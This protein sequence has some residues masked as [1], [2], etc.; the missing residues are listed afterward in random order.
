MN[1]AVNFDNRTSDNKS[2]QELSDGGFLIFAGKSREPRVFE[3]TPAGTSGVAAGAMG[4]C[5]VK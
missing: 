4:R 2:V 1:R 5:I 3:L